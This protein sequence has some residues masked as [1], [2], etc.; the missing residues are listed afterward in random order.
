M[1]AAFNPRRRAFLNLWASGA[2]AAAFAAPYRGD[3]RAE[4]PR[5]V[6]DPFSLGVA[7]GDRKS[8]V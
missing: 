3:A 8:V 1:S 6:N 2:A 5:W 7:S 4:T